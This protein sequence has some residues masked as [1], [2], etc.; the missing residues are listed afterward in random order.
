MSKKI[1]S[2]LIPTFCFFESELKSK[3]DFF[4]VVASFMLESS[5]VSSE[6]EKEL[7]VLVDF[8]SGS[9]VSGSAV[10]GKSSEFGSIKSEFWAAISFF[11][12]E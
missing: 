1:A 3:N 10:S 7:S 9:P 11:D 12:I 5:M 8:E 2:T 4:V 6:V